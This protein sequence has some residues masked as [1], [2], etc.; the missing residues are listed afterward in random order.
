[1]CPG[2][3]NQQTT[4]TGLELCLSDPKPMLPPTA[5]NINSPKSGN[6]ISIVFPTVTCDHRNGSRK[7]GTS[8]LPCSQI[9]VSAPPQWHPYLPPETLGYWC[10]TRV[11]S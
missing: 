3:H 2:S 6:I 11:S 10:H 5:M 9:S 1:M 4:D 8:G 7:M